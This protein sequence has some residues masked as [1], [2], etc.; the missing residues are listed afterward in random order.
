[1][2]KALGKALQGGI[3]TTTAGNPGSRVAISTID[4]QD[5]RGPLASSQIE[6][7]TV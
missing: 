3:V 4:M 6:P 2:A 5:G 1:M 7:T